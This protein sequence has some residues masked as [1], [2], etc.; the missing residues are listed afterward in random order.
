MGWRVVG[1]MVDHLVLA[2]RILII[3]TLWDEALPLA[4]GFAD[5]E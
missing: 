3:P 4:A 1:P 5:L 2:D